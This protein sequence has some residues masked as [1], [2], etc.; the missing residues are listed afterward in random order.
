MRQSEWLR[1][2]N[3]LGY[4]LNTQAAKLITSFLETCGDDPEGAVETLVSLTKA[5]LNAASKSSFQSV[6]DE[7]VMKAVITAAVE[8]S[9]ADDAEMEVLNGELEKE[10]FIFNVK[11]FTFNEA[12]KAWNPALHAPTLF[13]AVSSKN[14]IYQD[15]FRI[16]QRR[17]LLGGEF[18]TEG[19]GVTTLQAGQRM[20]TSVAS[21][22]GN[23]GRKLS[24]GLLRRQ[25]D[26]SNGRWVIEDLHKVL[27]VELAVET[28]RHLVTDGSFV[29]C[30]GEMR[31]G[32]F[33]VCEL[34]PLKAIPRQVSIEKDLL[35]VQI[36]T[37]SMTEEQ[38]KL[39]EAQESSRDGMYVV[40]SEVHL[41]SV[42]VLDMLETLFQGFESAGPPKAYILMGNFC[43]RSFVPTSQGVCA[44]REGFERLKFMLRNL[45]AHVMH[46][47]RFIFIPGPR[48]PGPQTLPKAPLPNYLTADLARDIPGAVMATNPCH[49]R[50]LS[51][52]IVF[53]RHDVLRLLRRHE[54]VPLARE[55]QVTGFD[56]QR[57]SECARFILDQAHLVPLPLEESNILWEYDHVLRLYPLPHAVFIG[58]VT[59]QFEINYERCQLGSVG[60]FASGSFYSFHP[61]EG[62]LDICEVPDRAG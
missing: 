1:E 44:Y 50:H 21:I 4:C 2:F 40:L 36:P 60:P 57:Y 5:H 39:L 18:A 8:G 16:L 33:Q 10:A 15:R 22:V 61:V 19:L 20:L 9:A 38:L 7:D 28:G 14:K 27:P 41:D 29:L 58:G 43:S 42:Q 35:P 46:G 54:A 26:E 37:A 30:E 51:R 45:E 62:L 55:T 17:L 24:F 25:E 52:E 34:H 32:V 6:I 47:T 12:T 53:F 31:D 56:E 3:A 59:P 49:V 48:D 13:P 23:P 11:P